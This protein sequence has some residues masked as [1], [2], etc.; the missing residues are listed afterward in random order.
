MAVEVENPYAVAVA[1]FDEAAERLGLSQAMRAIL[2]KPKR[3]LTVNFPV[4]MD[5]GDVEMFTG[6]RVQH[7]INR[8]PAKGG[9]RFSPEVSLDEV[10]ALAMWMTWKCAVVGIP[11]GGAKGGVICDPHKLSRAE[12]E[13]L[14]RRYAT[15]IS[16]LIGPDSD[17][18]APDMN[19]NPQ[20]MGWIM[21][22][23]SMHQG[24]SVPAVITGKPLAI[25]GSEGRLEATARGVQVVTREAMKDMGMNPEESVV[26]V[27]GFGNVGSITA[28][29]LH[30][31]G[32]KVVGLSDINGAVYNSNGIDVHRAL[33]Y[34]KEHGTLKGLPETE[35][36]T[37]AELLELPCDVLVPAALENQLTGRNASRVK[38][39][40][41]IEAANGPT[42]PDADHIFNDRGIIVVPD[43]LANAG[44]VTV[45]YFEWVQDLQRFFWAENEIN[46]RLESIM[47]R[48]YQAVRLKSLEQETN[49]RMGAYLLAVAR[50]AEATEIRGV[51]P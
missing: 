41:I 37:N 17:I 5:N 15:E 26:V 25:G 47:E 16:I 30:E 36:L 12:L 10:R 9:I 27:Q 21:D 45:S 6:Y 51:Y 42:T 48:S 8:G 20:I 43:I 13:R 33:R 7:N 31:L 44:G 28:R 34:S 3:E 35:S 49:L 32:C 40:L 24:Y 46:N 19:T 50:V 29:L 2:R 39:R 38:A 14:T 18:P 11:F 4:R 1:Q 22:T 23:Y